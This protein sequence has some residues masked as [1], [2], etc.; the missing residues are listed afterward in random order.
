MLAGSGMELCCADVICPVIDAFWPGLMETSFTAKKNEPE[1]LAFEN[2]NRI[3]VLLKST[4]TPP[5]PVL[6][7]VPVKVAVKTA[8]L[9]PLIPAGKVK[10]T[11]RLKLFPVYVAFV[12]VN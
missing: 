11:R 1:A 6:V 4:I 5:F 7:T 2:V 8:V 12:A 9:L 10:V 3:G